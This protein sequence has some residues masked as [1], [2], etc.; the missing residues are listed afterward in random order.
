VKNE[1]LGS[2]PRE[3]QDKVRL[4]VGLQLIL[5]QFKNSNNKSYIT[6]NISFAGPAVCPG[7]I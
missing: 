5:I 6:I 4:S 3:A 1:T 2:M 7:H